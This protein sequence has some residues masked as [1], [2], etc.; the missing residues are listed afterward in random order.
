M[1][2]HARRLRLAALAS[3]VLVAGCGIPQPG[4]DIDQFARGVVPLPAPMDRTLHFARS[5]DPEGQRVIFV[6]GTPGD[7]GAFSDYLASVPAGAE[8]I[9]IDRPGFGATGGGAVTSL[10]DQAAALE[11]LLVERGGRW[12]ILVGHSLGGPIVAQAAVD[13]PDRV[14]GILILAGSL[15]PDLER[16]HWVQ[17]VGDTWPVKAI[18]PRMLRMANEEVLVL[19]PELEALKPRLSDVICPVIIVHGTED[20]LVPFANV[21]FMRKMI[22]R[23]TMVDVVVLDGKDH[24]IPWDSKPVIDAAIERLLRGPA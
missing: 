13:F 20:S 17:R 2:G 22:P 16:I 8:F 14:G 11:A 12:P 23:K 15:D 3:L 4:T 19:K 7:A 24:F 10:A 1:R 9:S 5:G 18:I 6:H 21:D